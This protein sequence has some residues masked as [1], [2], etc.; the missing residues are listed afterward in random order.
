MEMGGVCGARSGLADV[1]VMHPMVM[2]ETPH[3]FPGGWVGELLC[4]C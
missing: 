3:V 1:W 2:G 4:V